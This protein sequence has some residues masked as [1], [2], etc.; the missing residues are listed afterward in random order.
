MLDLHE[1][2]SAA[3]TP[4]EQAALQRQI[5]TTDRQIDRSTSGT[6]AGM[7]AARGATPSLACASG[8]DGLGRSLALPVGVGPAGYIPPAIRRCRQE[9]GCLSEAVVAVQQ[10]AQSAE[11]AAFT[12]AFGGTAG[13]GVD[14]VG[15]AGEGQ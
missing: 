2:L 12:A 8:S 11:D 6:E 15:E 14:A 7:T 5:A 13:G 10:V 1:Q 4:H 3:K 9:V